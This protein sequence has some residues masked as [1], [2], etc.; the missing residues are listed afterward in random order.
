MGKFVIDGGVPL[1][2][3]VRISGAKNAAVAVI[4]A[5]IMAD[6]L[7]VI[8]NLPRIKDV[9]NWV[10][11]LKSMGAHVEYDG[12][13]MRIDG[14]M[15]RPV[16]PP[17]ELV[18][19]MRASYYL[20]GA[21]LGKFKRAVVG[22]PGGCSIGVRPIDQHIKGFEALGAKVDIEHG[23][24]M[25]RADKLVGTNIF[26]DVVSVGA[27]INIMLA[28]SMAQGVTIIENAA[29]E[30]HVVDVANFLNAMGAD[31][32]G[33]G[34]DNIRIKGVDKLSGCYYSIIPDQIEAGTFMIIA[35][36]THG[37]I[38][39]SNVIP[40]HLDSIIAKLE[41]T[42]T[43]II[44]SED[45][46]RVIGKRP[47][48]STDIRT[49]PYPGFPTDL[50]QPMAVLLSVV[51]GTS[52]ITENVWDNR[53]KYIDELKKMGAKVKV[54][55]RTAIIEGVKNLTG[56]RVSATDLRA[57]AAMV[58]AGLVAQGQTEVIDIVHIDRG[59]ESLEGKLKNLGARIK[60]VDE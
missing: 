54:E 57:G 53:F 58:L 30:P 8:D 59:Y 24:I 36:A 9:K 31:I 12:N 32:K 38:T 1:E 3:E 46:I 51:D 42:G 18:Q 35:A 50:Q 11:I 37:D 47:L 7:C 15:A 33:A 2:G 4:P 45:S 60:R 14:S 39:I 10:N 48:K 26:L 22:L 17:M 13:V 19:Q 20:V 43:L 25:A 44:P 56:A 21:M 5:A 16:E 34:T 23:V 55:G 52:M 49:Q 29:K 40:T 6:G 27:T 28:A 41:E